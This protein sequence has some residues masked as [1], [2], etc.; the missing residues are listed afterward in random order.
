MGAQTERHPNQNTNGLSVKLAELCGNTGTPEWPKILERKE[1]LGLTLSDFK[2]YYKAAVVETV[3]GGMRDPQLNGA[4][5][6]IQK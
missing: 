2:T 4:E 3:W 1:K 6:R 5:R